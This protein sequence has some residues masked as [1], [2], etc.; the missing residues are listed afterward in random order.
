MLQRRYGTQARAQRFYDSQLLD[1]LN[2]AMRAFIARQ[3]M[4]FLATSDVH[5]ECDV[6]DIVEHAF[7]EVRLSPRL[8]REATLSHERRRVLEG[9]LA[10]A[11]AL[12]LPVIAV[13]IESE[14]EREAMLE[15]GCDFGQ[16]YLFG[17]P[18]PAGS[19]E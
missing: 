3:E 10:L 5:G 6:N 7:D 15:A 4:M 11:H 14:P 12:E 8:V 13:G 1:H 2:P 16:G 18:I 19:V 9:T 17:R